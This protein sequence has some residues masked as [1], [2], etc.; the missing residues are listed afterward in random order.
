[1][2]Q[3]EDLFAEVAD[4]R[5]KAEE[6]YQSGLEY[7]QVIIVVQSLV[8]YFCLGCLIIWLVEEKPE[9]SQLS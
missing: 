4:Q 6:L 3:N 1:M 5:E 8:W 9:N 2:Q 7:Q